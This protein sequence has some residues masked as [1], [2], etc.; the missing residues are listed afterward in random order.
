MLYMHIYAIRY[1][2]WLWWSLQVPLPPPATAAA[3]AVVLI[4][5]RPWHHLQAQAGAKGGAADVGGI[6]YGTWTL[7]QA[8]NC[9][10]FSYL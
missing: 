3:G 4:L 1:N 6:Q 7:N 2:T 10:T 9:N 5:R 8:R